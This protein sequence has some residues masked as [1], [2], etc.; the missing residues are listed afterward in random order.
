MRNKLLILNFFISIFSSAQIEIGSMRIDTIF[1]VQIV[2]NDSIFEGLI[3]KD[4][5]NEENSFLIDIKSGYLTSLRSNTV[6]DEERM[7]FFRFKDQAF[8]EYFFIGESDLRTSHDTSNN[9]I[10]E[11]S[12]KNDI[13]SIYFTS[14]HG[15][16]KYVMIQ[17]S[18]CNVF[19][20]FDETGLISCGV[21]HKSML[22]AYVGERHPFEKMG[23]YRIKDAV[24]LDWMRIN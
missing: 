4:Y 3:I 19:L 17:H 20:Y 24:K 8:E 11:H 13:V 6:A 1:D 12:F 2:S 9:K 14:E 10:V 18:L 22:K 23:P 5:G 7:F 16:V 21:L 15:V